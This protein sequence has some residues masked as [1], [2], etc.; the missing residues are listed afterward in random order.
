VTRSVAYLPAPLQLHDVRDVEKLAC[1]VIA[2]RGAFLKGK[3]TPERDERLVAFLVE[4]A[5][6]FAHD[7]FDP[8]CPTCRGGDRRTCARCNGS[9]K[10]AS[11]SKLAF[12]KLSQ[13]MIDWARAEFGDSRYPNRPQ[14]ESVDELLEAQDAAE[15]GDNRRGVGPIPAQLQIVDDLTVTLE[16]LL[17]G[18]DELTPIAQWV[19]LEIAAPLADHYTTREDLAKEQHVSEAALDRCLLEL[20]SQLQVAA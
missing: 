3:M 6:R 7:K 4:E 5:W 11:F 18:M 15:L 8:S 16:G 12:E 13:R 20:A 17:E 1:S 2:R 19:M 9:G 10:G 14:L